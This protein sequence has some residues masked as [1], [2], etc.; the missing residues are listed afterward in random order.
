[1]IQR[2]IVLL[3]VVALISGCTQ[4]SGTETSA[5]AQA[6]EAP[7]ITSAM[8]AEDSYAIENQEADQSVEAETAEREPQD[9]KYTVI[10]TPQGPDPERLYARVG[11]TLTLE[12]I[13]ND[14]EYN[15]QAG[16]E[17]DDPELGDNDDTNS[18][19]NDSA[20]NSVYFS[21]YGLSVFERVDK[22]NVIDVKLI[23]NKAGTFEYGDE[24]ESVPM[25]L[26]IVEE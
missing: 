3:F 1:M 2:I 7:V 18:V 25:G 14:D 10:L 8:F 19:D 17:Y 20:D 22:G 23:L 24:T 26:L 6:V 21:I 16:N 11:D 13:N 4:Q 15:I 12:L 9:L 5:P